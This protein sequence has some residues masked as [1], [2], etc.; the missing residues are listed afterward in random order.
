MPHLICHKLCIRILSDK[1]DPC[2][3]LPVI[4]RLQVTPPV[5]QLTRARSKWDL[6]LFE[7]TQK[8]C[9]AAARLSA[10]HDK[11]RLSNGKTD[12]LDRIVN[13]SRITERHML[14]G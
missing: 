1:A 3:A 14:T 8:R 7:V 12:I 11:L 5:I 13:L 10:E 6:I 9:L 2:R 4:H